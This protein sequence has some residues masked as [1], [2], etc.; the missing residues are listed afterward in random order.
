MVEKHHSLYVASYTGSALDFIQVITVQL[1]VHTALMY[2]ESQ[3]ITWCVIVPLFAVINVKSFILLHDCV[4]DSYTPSKRLNAIIGNI[5]SILTTATSINWGLDHRTHHK[6]SGNISNSYNYPFNETVWVTYDKYR[7][8]GRMSRW[9][10]H[11]L[12]HPLVFFTLAPILYFGIQQRFIYVY[13]K[14]KHGPKIQ[15]TM[16]RILTNYAISHVGTIAYLY[17][18]YRAGHLVPFAVSIFMGYIIGFL[19]FFNQHTFNPVYIV[20][21]EDFNVVDAGLL[22]SSFIQIPRP[23]KWFFGGIEYHHLHHMNSRIPSYE[24][25]NY[26]EKV[27]VNHPMYNKII[28]LSMRDCYDNLWLQVYDSDDRKFITMTDAH[29]KLSC[30]K[31]N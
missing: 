29:M 12:F 15:Y 28:R 25:Q 6:T 20:D 23:L 14:L 16:S 27:F 1:C 18:I 11:I 13:K 17:M 31:L 8:M 19:L 4:H 5:T 2:T 22:G 9:L 26:H 21:N 7:K 24:L 30:E 3:L 10:A